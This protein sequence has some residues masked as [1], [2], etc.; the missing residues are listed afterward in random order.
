MA[1]IVFAIVLLRRVESGKLGSVK[2]AEFQSA[3]FGLQPLTWL[4]II[5]N[6]T[7]IDS[8]QC[9]GAGEKR[10]ELEIDCNPS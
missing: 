5:V 6:T 3:V 10:N 8:M 1:I 9:N 2:I 4:H 7:R